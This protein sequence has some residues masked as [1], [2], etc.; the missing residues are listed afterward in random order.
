MKKPFSL[1]LSLFALTIPFY[2]YSASVG[3]VK[4]IE[5]KSYFI[6]NKGQI[7]DQ[8]GQSNPFVN[9]ILPS[10]GL[11]VQIRRNGFS[12]DLIQVQKKNKIQT[13]KLVQKK[14][15]GKESIVLNIHRIDI[16]FEGSNKEVKL[17]G[18]EK[19]N[20]VYNFYQSANER[21]G[22]TGVNQYRRILVENLYP[23]IDLEYLSTEN[24][25]KYNFILHPG[26]N[27]HAIRLRYSG[28]PFNL[29][30]KALE[31]STEHG[32]FTEKLPASWFITNKGNQAIEIHYKLNKDSS[33]G[34]ESSVPFK[35]YDLVIDPLPNRAWGTYFGGTADD[36]GKGVCTDKF[37]NIYFTGFSRSTAGIASIGSHKSTLTG[38][39]DAFLA[40]FNALGQLLW[41]TYYGGSDAD[42][43]EE[44]VADSLGSV[45]MVGT[46]RSNNGISTPGSMQPILGGGDDGFL[47]K[48]SNSGTLIWATYIGGV[49][50][51]NVY[52][53]CIENTGSI[54][55]CGTTNSS[56]GIAFNSNHQSNRSGS[57][58]DAFLMKFSS[59]GVGLWGTYYGGNNG[60]EGSGI[61]LDRSGNVYLGGSTYSS[62]PANSIA[63]NGSHQSSYSSNSDGFLAKFSGLGNRLWATYYGGPGQDGIN[64]LEIDSNENIYAIGFTDGDSGI[65]SLGS[66]QVNRNNFFDGFLVKFSSNGVRQWG[67]YYGGEGEDLCRN[68]SIHKNA[69]YLCGYTMS[70][71]GIA[72]AGSFKTSMG[73]TRDAFLA[74]FS[75]VGIREWGTYY[76]GTGTENGDALCTD[77]AGNIYLGGT[78]NSSSGIANPGAHS[79]SN[80]SFN[81]AFLTR[82]NDCNPVT[83]TDS[84]RS[85]SSE[86]CVNKNYV[87]R[88]DSQTTNAVGYYWSLPAGWTILSGQN[89]RIITVNSGPSGILRVRAYNS[90]GDSSP[91]STKSILARPVLGVIDTIKMLSLQAC[92]NKTLEFILDTVTPNATGY[93]WSVPSGWT[94]INGQGT[95]YLSVIANSSGILSVKAYNNC[96][97]TTLSA[98]KQLILPAPLGSIDSI[99][100][101][102][103][104]FCA[105]KTYTLVLDSLTANAT[106]YFWS[107]P[108]G[109]ALINGQHTRSIQVQPGSTGI[110]RVRAYSDCSDSSSISQRTFTVTPA[111]G[112]IDSIRSNVNQ[113]CVGNTYQFRLDSL[114]PNAIGYYWVLPQGWTLLSGQHTNQISALAGGSGPIQVKAY[115]ICGDSSIPRQRSIFTNAILGSVDSIRSIANTFCANNVFV[116][117]LDTPTAN[118]VGYLW[119]VP[120]G[121]TIQSGQLTSTVSIIPSGSGSF[122]VRAYNACG[123]TSQLR[124]RTLLVSPP[125]S[126]FIDSIRSS[127]TLFCANKSHTFQLDSLT[128]NA[129]GYAWTF[130]SNWVVINNQNTTSIQLR[131]TSSGLLSVKAYN[132][133]GNF[134]SLSSRQITVAPPL[135][136][137]DSIRTNS[138]S[139]CKNQSY[140]FTLD[141]PSA[142]AAGYRWTIP[143]GW[144]LLSGQFTNSI[145]VIPINSG[146]IRVKAYNNCGDSSLEK[147]KSISLQLP[148]TSIDSIRSLSTSFCAYKSYVFNLNNASINANAYEWTVPQD[149]II[150]SGQGTRFLNVIP[151]SSGN[152]KVRAYNLCGD[153]T[154]ESIKFIE[155]SPALGNLSSIQSLD[156][157]YCMA[158]NYTFYTDSLGVNASG[159]QWQVPQGWQIN[160]ASNKSVINITPTSSGILSVRNYNNCGDTMTAI[161]KSI[162]IKMLGSIDTVIANTST[163]C[164]NDTHEFSLNKLTIDA[165]GYWWGLPAGWTIIDGQRSNKVRIKATQSGTIQVKAFSIC[166]DST[167]ASSFNKTILSNPA[168]PSGIQGPINACN[169]TIQTFTVPSA[170]GTI[171]YT[172]H[173]NSNWQ[174]QPRGDSISILLNPPSDTLRVKAIGVG[175]CSSDETSSFIQVNQSPMK[176]V[177]SGPSEVI[178]WDTVGFIVRS[179]HANAYTWTLSQ[180]W[181]ILSGQGSDSI[182]VKSSNLNTLLYVE[183]RNSCGDSS[184][185]LQVIARAPTGIKNNKLEDEFI[186]YPN[187]TI[188]NLKIEGDKLHTLKSWKVY[189]HLGQEVISGKC[190]GNQTSI[191]ISLA[192]FAKGMYLLHLEDKT[193]KE[194]KCKFVVAD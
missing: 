163:N 17:E 140:V 6:E 154:Q 155:T 47:A 116:F 194:Y 104:V 59:N 191:S 139:I 102:S 24:G 80:N 39:S 75:L 44:V 147:T 123:D 183:A 114:T 131:P 113:F 174:G 126:S 78:S 171:G 2:T 9:F 132:A 119:S 184:N 101:S 135:G 76:G 53:V 96:G 125:L 121:W 43:G 170:P 81:S 120:S 26:A 179:E 66:F 161:N 7:K 187:P 173:F 149:W 18:F 156:T 108:A 112:Q 130:P 145:Q 57:V 158:K 55:I 58:A 34:F 133:C 19:E 12:Y 77:L 82:M 22:I 168:K 25:F 28:A 14:D 1:V 10:K 21:L 71:T 50:T 49:S 190:S 137:L 185:S 95:S 37:G 128:A 70:A 192:N 94:I 111:M 51:D 69:I 162:S 107:L 29:T 87:F 99:R 5:S 89:T 48:F 62:A 92:A 3:P 136:T 180:G 165:D 118:A 67:T 61:C 141:Q 38:F 11:N 8:Y 182:L 100:V 169:G 97:D 27:I 45:F 72:T 91:V 13:P 16:T 31:F 144:I 193:D 73:G 54:Y 188:E 146:T 32:L 164:I 15:I 160:G 60:E 115:N 127:T 178:Y 143:N 122:G 42:F 105:G 41:G 109:W 166:G 157:N 46:T 30:N 186:V 35:D 63:S 172:W 23:K 74:K 64:C 20:G 93:L 177:I 138:T 40:K 159:Y 52:D 151:K 110:V 148:P 83:S 79:T 134:S 33:I 36:E 181:S 153:T 175:G 86:F 106:G 4:L 124:T 142:N 68:L 167:V 103:N 117:K 88:L 90:C 150:S 98:T 189:N 84:I 176:P 85:V 56:S 129:T 152:L 65:A